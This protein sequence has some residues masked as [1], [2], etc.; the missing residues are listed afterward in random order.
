MYDNY[1]NDSASENKFDYKVLSN[2]MVN[3]L[4]KQNLDWRIQRFREIDYKDILE[5]LLPKLLMTV[6]ELK[7]F[8]TSLNKYGMIWP[9]KKALSICKRNKQL[10]KVGALNLNKR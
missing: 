8:F 1:H 2:L 9:P 3:Q 5:K 7:Q 10:L 6:A 4:K